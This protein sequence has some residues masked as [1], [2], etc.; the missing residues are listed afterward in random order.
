MEKQ[1]EKTKTKMGM[2]GAEHPRAT[3][4]YGRSNIHVT[5]YWKEK[6]EKRTTLEATMTKNLP[7]VV[8][9]TKPQIRNLSQ[10]EQDKHGNSKPTPRYSVYCLQEIHFNTETQHSNSKGMELYHTNTN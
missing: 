2:R 9:D 7:K 4:N 8:T 6:G 1:R 10:H 5:G 3:G